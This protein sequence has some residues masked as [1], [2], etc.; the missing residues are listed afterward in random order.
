MAIREEK[1]IK[2]VQIWKEEV[3]LSVCRRYNTIHCCLVAQSYLTRLQPHGLQPTRLLC[4]GSHGISQTRILEWVAI[5]FS[6]VSSQPRDW[7][8]VYCQVSCSAGRFFTAEPLGKS[9]ILYTE[10]L[11]DATRK[12][13]ELINK[14][15]KVSAYKIN[16]PKSIAFLYTNNEISEREIKETIPFTTAS[17]RIKYLE[18]NLSKEAKDLC[19]ENYKMLMKKIKGD[20]NRWKDTLCFLALEESILLKWP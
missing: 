19:S 9:L 7:T 11:K 6:R 12:L 20:T 17:K 18:I 1:E 15:G 3:K 13:L 10:S 16:I 14:F 4:L 8:L 5:S 2:G